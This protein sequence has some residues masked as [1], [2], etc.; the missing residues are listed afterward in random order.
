MGTAITGPLVRMDAAD[1]QSFLIGRDLDG[2]W[3]A[4]ETHGLGG[5]LFR[6]REAAEHYAA[7][8]TARRPGAIRFVQ[9]PLRL[10]L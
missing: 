6:T 4:L 8:E 2:R 7:F 9:S 5:G 3:V 10:A 1:E